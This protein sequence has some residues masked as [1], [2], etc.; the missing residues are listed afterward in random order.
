MNRVFKIWARDAEHAV[1]IA[2]ERR[3]ILIA[4]EVFHPQ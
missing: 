2:N 4:N 1:K 3:A